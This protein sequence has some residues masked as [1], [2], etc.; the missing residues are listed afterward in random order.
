M[1]VDSNTV[2][3]TVREPA[4]DS[5][6]AV[7]RLAIEVTLR[8]RPTPARITAVAAHLL[9][10]SV[11]VR[12]HPH[13]RAIGQSSNYVSARSVG[14]SLGSGAASAAARPLDDHCHVLDRMAVFGNDA[15]Q[16]HIRNGWCRPAVGATGLADVDGSLMVH[17][18]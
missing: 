7:E 4:P 1:S 18:P 10:E 17:L 16:C 15:R 9:D 12:R 6:C 13:G 3:E 11:L 8:S 2:P 5:G 14:H